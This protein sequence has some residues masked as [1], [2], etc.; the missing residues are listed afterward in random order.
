MQSF[1]GVFRPILPK[2]LLGLNMLGPIGVHFNNPRLKYPPSINTIKP[3]LNK[4]LHA[5]NM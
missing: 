1:L 5:T 2:P 4:G 3:I